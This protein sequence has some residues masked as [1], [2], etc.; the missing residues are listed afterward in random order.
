MRL[1]VNEHQIDLHPSE[2]IGLTK[3]VNS[4]SDI[5]KRDSSFTKSFKVPRNAKNVAIFQGLG[6]PGS[7]SPM[8]YQ[9]NTAR[10]FVGNICIIYKGW[11]L[12]ENTGDDFELYIYDGHIDFMKSLDNKTFD[13][14]DLP[15]LT[16]TKEIS[17]IIDNWENGSN[18]FKYLLADYNGKTH[19]DHEGT[20]YINADYLIPSVPVN[21]LWERIFTTFGFTFSGSVF[22][23]EEFQNLFLTY[24]KGVTAGE[25]GVSNF[26]MSIPSQTIQYYS[27]YVWSIFRPDLYD[28]DINLVN[29]AII[30]N[31]TQ[32]EVKHWQI[33]TTGHY[34]IKLTGALTNDSSTTSFL[35]LG[36]NLHNTHLYDNDN[37]F[38]ALE[39]L[40]GGPIAT[41]LRNTTQIEIDTVIKLFA[42]DTLSLYYWKRGQGWDN[43][44]L[45]LE[46]EM[47][48]VNQTSIDQIE[49]FKN[50]TPKDFYKEILWRFGLT[51]FPSKD[52]NHIEFL[53]YEERINGET[54]DWSDK[55]IRQT[56]EKYSYDKYA[57]NNYFRFLYNGE[58]DEFNDGV[59]KIENEN[60]EEKVDIVKSKTYSIEK[61][62]VA[63]EVGPELETLPKLELWEKEP[64]EE[65][66]VVVIQY[67]PR[68][69][70]FSF[71]RE[72]VL[73]APVPIGSEQ[74]MVYGN[75][76]QV[77]LV[78]YYDYSWQK[79]THDRYQPILTL[80]KNTK[81][82]TAEFHMSEA[83]FDVFDLKPT[84]YVEQLGGEFLVDKLTKPDLN[85]KLTK[86][87]LIKINR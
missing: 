60:L 49:F 23:E 86:A 16:H 33:A 1:F 73:V 17:V 21:Y 46:W 85:K 7:T 28:F 53:T 42:G 18:Y 4:L 45:Q 25:D 82:I 8:P 13:D 87:E 34:R 26:T 44:T 58:G 2:N 70:R 71:V 38:E 9:K 47:V 24:P 3:Q 37:D 72:N 64:T 32:P 77:R 52:S 83:E 75:A 20:T 11:T 76:S 10:L 43:T 61:N 79:I 48:K 29:G 65:D 50:L 6:N 54:L 84:I 27:F 63:F 31:S 67:N 51:P 55:F 12:F 41:A 39:G 15:E 80:F 19:F 68:D 74:L 69:A 5:S 35:Y 40:L 81:I 62:P 59:I 30:N 78:E 36:K 14:I 57:K 56:G 66:G 22:A